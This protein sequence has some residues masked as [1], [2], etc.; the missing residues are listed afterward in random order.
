MS[1]TATAPP[2]LDVTT[3]FPRDPRLMLRDHAR[4]LREALREAV[5]EH[6]RRH[7][8]WHFQ[9]FAA[10]KYGY[11][12]RSRRYAALK[13]K[14]GLT[15]PLVFTGR[16]R[17]TVTRERQITATQ[18]RATLIL[19][20]PLAGG[21]GR[22]RLRRGQTTLSRAQRTVLQI[23]HE[24]KAITPDERRH[25]AHTLRDRYVTRANAPGVRYRTR[26]RGV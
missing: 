10:S 24:L 20:L 16:T 25:L 26:R 21:T 5:D 15:Q 3:A 2:R 22:F 11:K 4:F 19:R 17:D 8:P 12:P 7:I 13:A 23:I 18:Q 9:P 14:L 6:H 1:R